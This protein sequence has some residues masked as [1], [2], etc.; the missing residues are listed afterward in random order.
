MDSSFTAKMSF[1][2]RVAHVTDGTSG[3]GF[4]L[5]RQLAEL[6]AKIAIANALAP[7]AIET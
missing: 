3:I 1:E 4:A 2:G 5:A 6:G 7:G